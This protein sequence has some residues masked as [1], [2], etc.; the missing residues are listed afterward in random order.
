MTAA[1]AGRSIEQRLNRQR[2]IGYIS[3]LIELAPLAASW[4]AC[5]AR[6]R[7]AADEDSA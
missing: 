2:I 7:H 6:R 1:V 4:L 3:I 5:A